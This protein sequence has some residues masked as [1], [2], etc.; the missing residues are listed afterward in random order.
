MKSFKSKPDAKNA[1]ELVDEKCNKNYHNV[2]VKHYLY[3][4]QQTK[5]KKN[6]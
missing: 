5:E 4:F 2:T 1:S 3:S 6:I